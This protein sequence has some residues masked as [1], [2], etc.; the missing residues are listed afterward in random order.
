MAG[1]VAEPVDPGWRALLGERRLLGL[2][3]AQAAL[4][5]GW[6]VPTV[7]LPVYLVKVAGLP[8]WVPS[9]A[10]TLNAA[11][12]VL[13]QSATTARMVGYSRARVAGWAAA[14]MFGAIAAL[15]LGGGRP[16]SVLG[17]VLLF[18]AG[19]LLAGPACTAIAATAAPP[20]AR[21]RF[22]A[23]VNLAWSVSAVAG[24]LLVGALIE[25]H[26][27]LFWSLLAALVAA[28]G[29]GFRLAGKRQVD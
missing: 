26:A 14:L 5:F 19:Q 9:T 4:G 7:V 16:W 12:I 21:G 13:A 20:A 6:L 25:R 17:A 11:V 15:A 29:L 24:P 27:P 3:A 2:L 28:G 22:L 18:T 23:L 10:L 8:A 1:R